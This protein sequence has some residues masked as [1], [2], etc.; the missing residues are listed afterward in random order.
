MN[1]MQTSENDEHEHQ[2]KDSLSLLISILLIL[3]HM[4]MCFD[5]SSNAFGSRDHG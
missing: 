3:K 1:E 5:E 2:T 4:M